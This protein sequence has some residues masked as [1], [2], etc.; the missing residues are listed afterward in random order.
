MLFGSAGCVSLSQRVD[1]SDLPPEW[2]ATVPKPGAAV[3]DIAGVFVERGEQITARHVRGG[4]TGTASLSTFL[5]SQKLQAGN[6]RRPGGTTAELRRIDE[7]H[8]EL[9]TRQGDAVLDRHT[10]EIAVEK[11]TGMVALHHAQSVP[12]PGQMPAAAYGTMTIRLWRAPDGRLYAHDTRRAIGAVAVVPIM[13]SSGTWSRWEAA[14][15][16]ALEKQAAALAAQAESRRRTA[17]LNRL[18]A[19]VGAKAPAFAGADVVTGRPVSNADFSGKVVVL[20]AWST[21]S[22]AAPLGTLRAI[23]EKY[24][25]SGLAIVGL[26]TNP[27]DTRGP[28]VEFIAAHRLDWPHLYDGKGP[29][30]EIFEAY[31]G[32]MP[33]RYFVI[34]RAGNVAAIVPTAAS[35]E[36]AVAAALAVP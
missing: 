22:A 9:I 25:A 11:S 12:M 6:V 36:K 5:L 4:T 34:D 27:P 29:R 26:C 32:A 31:H 10:L 30:G 7:T 17:E 15:P 21:G 14:T 8:L 35:V 19:N 23:S 13:V 28:V 3:A 24:R 20:H 1:E 18:R 33:P 2:V 16:E